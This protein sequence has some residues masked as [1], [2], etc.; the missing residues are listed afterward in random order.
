MR[1]IM[2]GGGIREAE[3]VGEGQQRK[4]ERLC[5]PNA[6]GV[7]YKNMSCVAHFVLGIVTRRAHGM[8][9]TSDPY[10]GAMSLHTCGVL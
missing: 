6:E 1:L 5:A 9:V 8:Q 2:G 10:D 3:V 4:T 7:A